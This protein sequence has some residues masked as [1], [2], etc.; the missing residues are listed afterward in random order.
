M[1]TSINMRKTRSTTADNV[2]A[3]IPE[4]AKVT[5]RAS[6]SGNWYK[7]TY[8]GKTGYIKGGYFA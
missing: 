8:N 5:V 7:V 2:I 4:G 3:V 1:S 6:Y